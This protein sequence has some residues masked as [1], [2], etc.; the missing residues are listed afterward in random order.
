MDFMP[1][2]HV[3]YPLVSHN[4]QLYHRVYVLRSIQYNDPLTYQICVSTEKGQFTSIPVYGTVWLTGY[5][6][7]P[8][9]QKVAS[10]ASTA[11]RQTQILWTNFYQ[12][13]VYFVQAQHGNCGKR[14]LT[15]TKGVLDSI[16]SAK[17]LKWC[18]L[19]LNNLICID[20][21][22]I[23]LWCFVVSQPIIKFTHFHG[24]F[25]FKKLPLADK[26]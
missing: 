19:G 4:L 5:Q 22:L 6:S 8:G 17:G 7:C 3:Y 21:M 24:Q 14:Y 11:S 1:Y 16:F 10:G 25:L 12:N 15:Q 20:V 13:H 9:L 18:L 23:Y 26:K 2:L